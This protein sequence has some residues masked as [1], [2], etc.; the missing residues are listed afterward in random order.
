MWQVHSH[1]SRGASFNGFLFGGPWF[2]AHHLQ[3]TDGIMN[4]LPLSQSSFTTSYLCN[5]PLVQ[6]LLKQHSRLDGHETLERTAHPG[7]CFGESALVLSPKGHPLP[8]WYDVR[9]PFFYHVHPHRKSTCEAH[10]NLSVAALQ[11]RSLCFYPVISFVYAVHR[12]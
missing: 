10:S 6:V 11:L 1:L 7:M 5:A 2:G 3:R 12:R 4:C 9:W 8:R